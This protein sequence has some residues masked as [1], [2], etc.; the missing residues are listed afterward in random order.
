MKITILFFMVFFTCN[1]FAQ[2][3]YIMLSRTRPLVEVEINGRKSAMLI[4][5]GSELNLITKSIIEVFG[6][7]KHITQ[8][9]AF[10]AGGQISIWEVSKCDL[11]VKGFKVSNIMATDL[12]K[13]CESIENTTGVE[14]VGIL[15][16]PG[17]KE[18]GMIINLSAGIFSIKK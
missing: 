17:I 5:T 12:D 14:V 13:T 10:G 7:E 4:D 16:A 6:A 3:D 8:K 2:N 9:S 15:G 18:I 1:S 11:T